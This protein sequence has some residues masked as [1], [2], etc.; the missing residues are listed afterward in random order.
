[1]TKVLMV[2][3]PRC[4]DKFNYYVSK[5]RPFCCEKCK[6]V[7]LGHWLTESYAVPDIKNPDDH[8]KMIDVDEFAID[9]AD[10]YGIDYDNEE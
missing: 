10:Q 4:K 9:E 8:Q 3:C 7:D 2:K 1:M 6:M 5:F